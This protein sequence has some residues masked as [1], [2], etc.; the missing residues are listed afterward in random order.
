MAS[1]FSILTLN[2]APE[3]RDEAISRFIASGPI[4][5]CRDAIPGFV[6][7]RLLKSMDD[8]SL[9]HVLVEWRDRRAYEDWMA[10]PLRGG[11][12]PDRR[13]FSPPTRSHLFELAH[14]VVR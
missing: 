4:E 11:G 2:A 5:K 7:G 6:S 1:F 13:L 8:P 14:E 12:D 9:A 10:S 3:D